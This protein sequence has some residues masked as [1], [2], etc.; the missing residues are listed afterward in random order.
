MKNFLSLVALM[1]F[2]NGLM[3]HIN[4]QQYRAP[5]E[6]V[7]NYR[8]D[9]AQADGETDMDVNNVRAKLLTGGD[10][11]WNLNQGKYVVPAVEPGSGQMEVSSIFAGAVW[12]GGFAA[13]GNLKIAA[14]TYRNANSNDYWPGPLNPTTG[15]VDGQTCRNWDQFFEVQGSEIDL[16]RSR[17]LQAISGGASELEK[18]LI[19]DGVKYWPGKGNKFFEERFGFALPATGQGLGAFFDRDENG[20]YEPTKGDFPIIEIR[21]CEIVA[22]PDEMIYWIYNDNGGIHTNSNSEPIR[23]EIQV[24]TFAFES[25]DELNNMTFQR[26][27]LINRANTV[28]DSTFFAMWVDPDLGCY[29]DDYVGCDVERALGYIYNEDAV[30]GDVGCECFGT[31]TYCEDVPILGVDYFRG[32]LSDEL[33]SNFNPIELGLSSFTYYNNNGIGSPNPATTDPGA[34]FE[35]YNYLSG[36]WRDGTPFTFGGDAY[37]PGSTDEVDYAFFNPPNDAAG[38][39]M[40][41]ETLPFGDRRTIQASGPFTLLPGAVNEL[42]IGVVWIPEV[43]YPCPDITALLAADDL[44]QSLFDNCFDILDGPDAPDVDIVELDEELI[45]ILSN[46]SIASNNAGEEYS[47]IDIFA[48]MEVLGEDKR[49]EFEG[50][51]VFQL[52]QNEEVKLDDINEIDPDKARLIYEVDLK[53]GVEVL[54]NWEPLRDPTDISSE[55]IWVPSIQSQGLENGIRKSL[56]VTQDQFATDNR[57]LVNHREYYFSAIA[58][59]YNEYEEF[60]ASTGLGQRKPFLVGRRN[61]QT[62]TGVP[63][64]IVYE[65]LNASFG[66]GPVVTRLDGKGV[67]ERFVDVSQEQR[68][69][70]LSSDFDGSITYAP[71]RGPIE[72]SVINPLVIKDGTYLLDFV[73]SDLSDDELDDDARWVITEESTGRTFRS[74]TSVEQFNDQIFG[75]LGFSVAIGQSDSPGE[76]SDEDNGAIGAEGVYSDSQ[77]P[78]WFAGINDQPAG[79]QN[80]FNFVKTGANEVD[81][82]LDFD[83]GLSNLGGSAWNPYQL[84]DYRTT[85]PAP[86]P[87]V[88]LSPAWLEQSRGA[89]VRARGSLADL[90]NVDIVFTSDKSLWSRCVVVETATPY[91]TDAQYLINRETEGDV[92]QFDLRGAPSVGK[93]DSDGNGLPD[94]DGDGIGMGWFPGYAVD[95]E[96]GERLNVFFGEN[97]SYTADDTDIFPDG[98]VITR[99]M[100]YNPN[101]TLFVPPADGE[102]PDLSNFFTGGQHYVYVMNTAYDEG[103]NLRG[104]LDPA[105]NPLRKIG[106]LVNI[107]YAAIGLAAE[108]TEF[109][110]YADGLIPNDYTVKLRVN[111]PYAVAEGTGSNEDHPS[112]R[113]TFEGVESQNLAGDEEREEALSNVNVVPNPYFAYSQYETEQELSVVRITNLPPQATVTIY[114]LDGRFIRQ[115]DRNVAGVPQINRS[116]PGV[117]QTQELPFLEWDLKNSRGISVSAGVYL[118]HIEAPQIGERVIKW[119]GVNR[120]FNPSTLQ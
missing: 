95:V 21:G 47:E 38:W 87:A 7:I 9:C 74:E 28:L 30:D 100:M 119:F 3:A 2:A 10:V 91:F 56:Q 92:N 116:N 112:Y 78:Q 22:F 43:E 51:K 42:I 11:W 44:A 93:E 58:Y 48:P 33:D 75:D 63:R 109:L 104:L 5:S 113:F 16:F 88:M 27:K 83:Q 65:N 12:I 106:A 41:Q 60:D 118:I 69:A 50:Y 105:Q 84:L 34:D 31:P 36:S 90:N 108:G 98:N 8:M 13:G 107:T 71:G 18:D 49:Y 81:Q 17:Y 53:N 103:E 85:Q 39:S 117:P 6:R 66:D 101:S 120:K 70:F 40:C 76:T 77:G 97:S 37:N 29:T 23:M 55:I 20:F 59:A 35:F 82:S 54:Y 15:Q 24:Q 102:V 68:E 62:Y 72:V 46:D 14:Q 73:D 114:S 57:N 52:A 115:Y 45:L 26:Y 79:T 1:C 19:P 111:S 64:P 99:D 4:P 61:A 89:L 67:G 80:L 25:N 110:S 86:N 32:P 96:T 94:P